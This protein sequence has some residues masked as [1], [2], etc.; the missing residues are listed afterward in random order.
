MDSIEI[1]MPGPQE[2]RPDTPIA[3][4]EVKKRIPLQVDSRERLVFPLLWL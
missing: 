4:A 1:I 3:P 2:K